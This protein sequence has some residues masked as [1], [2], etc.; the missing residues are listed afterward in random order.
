MATVPEKL[1]FRYFKREAKKFPTFYVGE[2]TEVNINPVKR[3]PGALPNGVLSIEI[4]QAITGSLIAICA[5]CPKF[6][7]LLAIPSGE[8]FE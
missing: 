3:A 2:Q 7:V 4:E 5:F 6:Q 8:N 1:V